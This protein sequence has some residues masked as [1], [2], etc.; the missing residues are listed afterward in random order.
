LTYLL[1]TSVLVDHLRSRPAATRALGDA[2]TS[3]RRV[4][5][6]VLTRV[7]LR[8]GALPEEIGTIEAVEIL[9]DW[10]PVDHE[11]ADLA[12]RCAERYARSH[13]NIDAGDYVIAATAERLDAELLTRH[14]ERFPM[15]PE[16]RAPY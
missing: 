11:I 8:R 10:V 13:P 9:L 1:D 15:F 2:L 6:S 12:A 7:E 3:G 16:L 5:A 4:A 14:V